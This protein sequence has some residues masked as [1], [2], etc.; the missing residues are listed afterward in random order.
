MTPKYEIIHQTILKQIQSG[1]LNPNDPLPG[2]EERIRG[3][4]DH[5][6][7]RHDGT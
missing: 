2:E 4:P 1:A 7:P 3:E 5:R 6:A